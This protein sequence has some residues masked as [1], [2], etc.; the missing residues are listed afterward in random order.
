MLRNL[1]ILSSFRLRVV[2]NFESFRLSFHF[3]GV[4]R[5]SHREKTYDYGF[6][7]P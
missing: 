7:L 2:V 4:V 1:T 5:S 6:I 3:G